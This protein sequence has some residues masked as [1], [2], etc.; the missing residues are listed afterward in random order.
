M[1]ESAS[2]PGDS[3][4]RTYIV[5]DEPGVAQQLWQPRPDIGISSP[6]APALL[7]RLADTC[8]RCARRSQPHRRVAHK[9]LKGKA[10]P[11][12]QRPCNGG[13]KASRLRYEREHPARICAV[14]A[15]VRYERGILCI[16]FDYGHVLNRASL[17]VRCE[18]R[19]NLDREDAAVNADELGQVAR[20]K[21]GS[22]S[23]VEQRLAGRKSSA[24]PEFVR[25]RGSSFPSGPDRR[26]Q[27]CD[28]GRNQG[29]AQ[30]FPPFS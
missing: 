5:D 11:R 18:T 13:R 25:G 1:P 23:D 2:G 24:L 14:E 27:K 15:S 16:A 30:A 9:L 10:P 4:N 26:Q 8:Q 20:R 12:S 6:P 19:G 17:Q 21:S 7:D 29:C 3:R 22:R 28:A